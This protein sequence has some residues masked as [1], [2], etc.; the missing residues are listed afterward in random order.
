MAGRQAGQRFRIDAKNSTTPVWACLNDLHQLPTLLEFV[1]N[2][3][4]GYVQPLNIIKASIR[5]TQA[6]S[7]QQQ[8]HFLMCSTVEHQRPQM[9]WPQHL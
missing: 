3:V 2:K 7:S 8:C 5:D 9:R 1:F 4:S 6:A